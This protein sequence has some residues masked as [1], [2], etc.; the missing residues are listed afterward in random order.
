MWPL[1]GLAVVIAALTYLTT[2][3]IHRDFDDLRRHAERDLTRDAEALAVRLDDEARRLLGVAVRLS[4]TLQP[5]VAV[6][7]D[8]ALQALLAAAQQRSAGLSITVAAAP[9]T[10]LTD[11]PRFRGPY[12]RGTLNAPALAVA[13]RLPASATHPDRQSVLQ[14]ALPRDAVQRLL[15]ERPLPEGSVATLIDPSMR[16]IARSRQIEAFAGTD[17]DQELRQALATRTSGVARA[18]ADGTVEAIAFARAPL[19]GF[20]ASITSDFGLFAELELDAMTRALVGSLIISGLS[21]TVI[22]LIARRPATLPPPA[23]ADTGAPPPDPAIPAPPDQLLR[24]LDALPAIVVLSQSNGEIRYCNRRAQPQG[25]GDATDRAPDLDRFVHPEDRAKLAGWRQTRRT[26]IDA[27]PVELRCQVGAAYRWH[28]LQAERIPGPQGQPAFDLTVAMDIEHLV[29][30][31]ATLEQRLEERQLALDDARTRLAAEAREISA[32]QSAARQG[33]PLQALGR[34]GP[35]VAHTVNNA[36]AAVANGYELIAGR[37]SDPAVL[38]IVA[39]GRSAINRAAQLTRHIKGPTGRHRFAD[40]ADLLPQ[41]HLLAEAERGQTLRLDLAPAAGLWPA[42]VDGA[43]LLGTLLQLVADVAATA[44]GPAEVEI[45]AVNLA[46]DKAPA[47]AE[48][49][50]I[51][52]RG[53]APAP[54]GLGTGLGVVLARWLAGQSGG[55]L[56]L[57]TPSDAG[58]VITLGLPRADEAITPSP[59]PSRGDGDSKRRLKVL[60][61]DDNDEVRRSTDLLLR[62]L[63]FQ[64]EAAA[65]ITRALTLAQTG[66]PF[67][68]VITDVVMPGGNGPQL[69]ERLRQL[70]PEVRAIYMTGHAGAE[71]ADAGNVVLHKPF[72]LRELTEL[73]AGL[74]NRATS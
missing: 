12:E 16:V 44:A 40:I 52:L 36:L 59:A 66:P 29:Q 14:V 25:D 22:V 21:T 15:A 72:S 45:S 30:A 46:A 6:G 23:Q 73:V 43:W 57:E 37:S 74:L 58:S 28:R 18:Q 35:G 55:D 17:I 47:F 53:P 27:P 26:G 51:R 42:K 69:I 7:D 5:A 64:V 32:L 50:A 31:R 63:G 71:L 60:L 39:S 2:R 19:S 41:L 61:V 13:L 33:L 38:D 4:D 11:G 70:Q 3:L 49:V 1:L 10:K 67:D 65:D 34:L 54:P 48:R 62:T 9:N 56:T 20:A 24:M 8:Q 68:L